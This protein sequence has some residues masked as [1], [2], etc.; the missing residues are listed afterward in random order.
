MKKP[1]INKTVRG[2]ITLALTANMIGAPIFGFASD[3]RA[4]LREDVHAKLSYLLENRWLGYTIG[5]AEDGS[6][7]RLSSGPMVG[8][9]Y[10]K[11]AP[12]KNDCLNLMIIYDDSGETKVL[13]AY[14][15][16]PFG[17]IDKV[18]IL[19]E[20]GIKDEEALKKFNKIDKEKF[21]DDILEQ[22]NPVLDAAIKYQE[23]VV[24]PKAGEEMGL[25]GRSFKE[26]LKEYHDLKIYKQWRRQNEAKTNFRQTNGKLLSTFMRTCLFKR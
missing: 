11:Q 5:K 25:N 23:E 12:I 20:N 26:F 16:K 9:N 17:D 10:L 8:E 13:N 6:L 18:E 1:K 22:A 3:T 21:L 15:Q 7:V 24:I 19:G 2:L 14:D 4:K